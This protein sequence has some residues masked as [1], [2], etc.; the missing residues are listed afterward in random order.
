MAYPSAFSHST[1]ASGVVLPHARCDPYVHTLHTQ[2]QSS[3]HLSHPN[4]MRCPDRL[5][6]SM[7]RYQHS[8]HFAS[9]SRPCSRSP[10]EGTPIA[11]WPSHSHIACARVNT[12]LSSISAF[13]DHSPG[14]LVVNTLVLCTPVNTTNIQSAY[15]YH[16]T[17]CVRI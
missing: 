7:H 12:P 9:F 6:D 2:S 8:R 16:S 10:P 17:S 3:I 15:R 14:A 4:N 5:Y 11:A 1:D 13:R